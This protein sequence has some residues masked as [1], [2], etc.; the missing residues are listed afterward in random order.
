VLWGYSLLAVT[1]FVLGC[2]AFAFLPAPPSPPLSPQQQ[3][4]DTMLAGVAL[5]PIGMFVVLSGIKNFR[6]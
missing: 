4:Q 6:K 1:V 3:T 5:L 2:L